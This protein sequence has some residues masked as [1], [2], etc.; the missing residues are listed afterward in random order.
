MPTTAGETYLNAAA[1]EIAKAENITFAKAYERAMEENPRFYDLHSAEM[2]KR[3]PRAF[4]DE[5]RREEEMKKPKEPTKAEEE[6]ELERLARKRAAET[7]EPIA[8]A[9]VAV[10][11]T[12]EGARLYEAISAAAGDA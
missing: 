2:A 11:K 3:N 12:E 5:Q 8:K 6:E 7:G 9:Y 4:A 1:E 10:L